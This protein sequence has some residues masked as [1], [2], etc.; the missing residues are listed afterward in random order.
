MTTVEQTGQKVFGYLP[1]DVPPWW[2]MIILGFQHVI[3]MFPAT[4]LVALLVGFDVSTVLFVSGLATITA[5]ILSKLLGKKFIPLYYGSSF[6]YIAAT[7]A[8]TSA[9][10]GVYAGADVVRLAQERH[11]RM[12][13]K[14]WRHEARVCPEVIEFEAPA[15]GRRVQIQ[16]TEPVGLGLSGSGTY[17]W[18]VWHEGNPLDEGNALSGPPDE[19]PPLCEEIETSYPEED[20]IPK[21]VRNRPPT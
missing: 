6:S 5:L 16:V 10:F 20:K 3:T 13:K 8:L 15:A 21:R 14:R 11:R 4:V 7:L 18:S 17:N 9:K 12:S 1:D 2:K 19:W